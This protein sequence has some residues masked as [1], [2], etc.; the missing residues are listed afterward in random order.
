RQDHLAVL[1]LLVYAAQLVGDGP[2]Q[3]SQKLM[4][5]HAHLPYR[6]RGVSRPLLGGARTPEVRPYTAVW[7]ASVASAL[8]RSIRSVTSVRR[9]NASPYCRCSDNGRRGMRARRRSRRN[10]PPW[11]P[12]AERRLVSER[13]KQ[14]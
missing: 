6:D 13:R 3:S 1:G 8:T 4:R 5:T 11:V 14:A 7:T 9:R 12:A 10:V 2:D